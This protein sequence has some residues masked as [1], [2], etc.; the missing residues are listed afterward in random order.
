MISQGVKMRL[1]TVPNLAPDS[2]SL[3]HPRNTKTP[4]LSKEGEN[5]RALIQRPRALSGISEQ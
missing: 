1:A 2:R 4:T 3:K 5:Y